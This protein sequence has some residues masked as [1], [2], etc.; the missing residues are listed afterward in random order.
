MSDCDSN[1]V[2]ENTVRLI[3]QMRIL[4]NVIDGFGAFVHRIPDDEDLVHLMR[5]IHESLDEKFQSA[6]IT[7]LDI[8]VPPE[9]SQMVVRSSPGGKSMS[10][11]LANTSSASL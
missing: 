7:S 8:H 2:S 11:D 1:Q 4:R 3:D 6:Y 5:V 10:V 9:S